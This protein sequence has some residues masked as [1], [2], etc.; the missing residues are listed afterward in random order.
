MKIRE[1]R[2]KKKKKN[3]TKIFNTTMKSELIKYFIQIVINRR[4]GLDSNRIF[5]FKWKLYARGLVT[6]VITEGRIFN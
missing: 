5:M 3:T 2:I 6:L 1:K 4:V